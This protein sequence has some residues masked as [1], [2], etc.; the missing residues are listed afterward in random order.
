MTC[1]VW[2]WN[3]RITAIN[4]LVALPLAIG[5]CEDSKANSPETTAKLEV[6]AAIQSKMNE[7]L[8][9]SEALAAAAPA[10]SDTGWNATTD[11]PAI[12]AMKTQWRRARVAYESIEGAIAVLFPDLDYTTDQRYDAFLADH[13]VGDANL[14]DSE[15]V[16]G[17]HAIERILWADQIPA[18]VVT[19]EQ[20]LPG[21]SAAAF[22]KTREEAT[23][24]K[25][26]L[27]ARLVTDTRTMKDM[28]SPLALDTASAFRGVIGSMQEQLEKAELAATGEEESRYAGYTLAD[29]RTNVEAGVTTFAAFKPWLHATPGGDAKIASIETAFARVRDAY[30]QLSGDALP[31]VPA[32]WSSSTPTAADLQTPFG[33]LWNVL[34][35][36]ADDMTSG[37][38]VFEMTA[39]ADLMGIPQIP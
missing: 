17:V 25:T 39:A 37:S 24:F 28:F 26:K 7:L 21:Y 8:A 13:P 12:A 29:M 4:I 5:G 1:H 9:A 38:L 15:I 2:S 6:K 36:E 20:A 19:F 32:T 11:A 14:F 30:A 31:E 35:D 27:C 10:A 18:R 3:L 23:D 16:T 33:K 22:P 34:H